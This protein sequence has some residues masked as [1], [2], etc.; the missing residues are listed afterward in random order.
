MIVYCPLTIIGAG[1]ALLQIVIPRF[2]DH[3]NEKPSAFVGH[4]NIMFVPCF[5]PVSNGPSVVKAV[6]TEAML[7]PLRLSP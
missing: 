4:L 6:C 5:V 7:H 1:V 2:V 3:C